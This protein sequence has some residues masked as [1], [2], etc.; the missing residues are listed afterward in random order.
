MT[1]A[2]RL[3][4]ARGVGG[5]L[6]D[7]PWTVPLAEWDDARLVEIRQ[8]GLSRHTVRFVA[9]GGA[10]YALKELDARLARREYRLL[11][12]LRSL[13]LPAVEVIGVVVDRPDQDAILVTRFLDHSSSYRALFANAR[14]AHP[15]DR[16][17]DA[18]VELLVR[19]H[20]AGFMWGDCSLSNVLF[21]LDAGAF[22]AYLVD[23]ETAE[24]HPSLSEGQRDYDVSLARERIAGE[25]FDLA[26]AG[27]LP[28]DVDPIDVADDTVR[29]YQGL[30]DELTREEILHPAEQRYRIAERLRRINS[31]GFDVDEVELV[32]V[33]STEGASGGVGGRPPRK[34]CRRG[35]GCA[36]A[37]ASPSLA[38]T[39][40]S[41]W[42]A[43]GWTRRRT[44]RG[45]CSTTS[46]PSAAI[47]NACTAARCRRSWRR[48]S[49][50]PRCTNPS[51]KR[52][53]RICATAWTTSSCS[54]RSSNTAGTCRRGRAGT[55]A[56]RRR[57]RTTS[58]P[59]CRPS[60]RT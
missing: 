12:E 29:R 35:R 28:D 20:L 11:R 21:R 36:C 10:V 50:S 30:W 5:G 26:A 22:A 27:T 54:T 40:A 59:C 15:T 8:R 58:R 52:S 9:E 6:L 53:R 16:L 41:S 60:P 51:S 14:Y 24:L 37:R 23:A 32:D 2:L 57:P 19:L 34:A 55:S 3:H 33:R 4:P 47:S 44:R 17:L 42:P 39:G 1:D 43:P 56:R 25:L 48:T 31:L 45:G 7:L 49:G 13:G 38:T 46:P 18:L